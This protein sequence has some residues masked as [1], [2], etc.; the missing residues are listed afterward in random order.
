MTVA[1][2]RRCDAGRACLAYLSVWLSTGALARDVKFD[3]EEL[4]QLDSLD[5][6]VAAVER[7]RS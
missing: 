7:N 5:A 1:T 2:L 3:G 6:I 4:S